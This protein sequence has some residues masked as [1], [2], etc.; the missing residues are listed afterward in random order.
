LIIKIVLSD[1]SAEFRYVIAFSQTSINNVLGKN[2]ATRKTIA[3]RNLL[4]QYNLSSRQY[5]LSEV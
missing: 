1:T 3:H 4:K 2:K 5:F